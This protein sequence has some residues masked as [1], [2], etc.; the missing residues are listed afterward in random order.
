MTDANR[1]T[2]EWHT[3]WISQ[4]DG[5]R[6][7]RFNFYHSDNCEYDRY[8]RL[9]RIWAENN[10]YFLV[11]NTL[12]KGKVSGWYGGYKF[13]GSVQFQIPYILPYPRFVRHRS[14]AMSAT[15]CERHLTNLRVFN[16]SS[17]AISFDPVQSLTTWFLAGNPSLSARANSERVRQHLRRH[18][19]GCSHNCFSLGT[20]WAIVLPIGNLPRHALLRLLYSKFSISDL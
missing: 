5:N 4:N 10:E 11:R 2:N 17:S 13:T 15:G 18:A 20:S 8:P 12:T 16:E 7:S 19:D 1:G 6:T 14:I 3:C 9:T